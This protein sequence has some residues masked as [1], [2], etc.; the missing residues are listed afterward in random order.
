V[1]TMILIAMLHKK[2]RRRINEGNHWHGNNKGYMKHHFTSID[3]INGISHENC[4]GVG[5]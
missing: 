5:P 3:L 1:S 2:H 4:T